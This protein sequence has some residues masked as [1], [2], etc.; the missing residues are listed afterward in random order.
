MQRHCALLRSGRRGVAT[1][2]LTVPLKVPISLFRTGKS[3]P[4]QVTLRTEL[5]ATIS[6]MVVALTS[7]CKA[8]VEPVILAFRTRYGPKTNTEGVS[9]ERSYDFGADKWTFQNENAVRLSVTM[10]FVSPAVTVEMP[11]GVPVM[12]RVLLARRALMVFEPDTLTFLEV[13]PVMTV[14]TECPLLA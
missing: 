5:D 2:N 12:T 1:E 4:F 10:T 14:S 8:R 6:T 11:E 3:L 9:G 7:P 13:I